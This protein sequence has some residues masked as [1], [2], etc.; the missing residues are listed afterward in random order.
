M[1]MAGIPGI[2][3]GGGSISG[4]KASADGDVS[5][6]FSKKFGNNGLSLDWKMMLI[7]GAVAVVAVVW[8]LKGK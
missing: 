6:S 4:G 3:T 5:A 8:I 2:N 1:N 7:V